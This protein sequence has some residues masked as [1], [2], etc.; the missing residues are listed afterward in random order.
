MVL[1]R[2]TFFDSWGTLC[3]QGWNT[4]FKIT[5][6]QAHMGTQADAVTLAPLHFARAMANSQ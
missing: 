2:S 3:M 5:H 1:V 6:M 4:Q